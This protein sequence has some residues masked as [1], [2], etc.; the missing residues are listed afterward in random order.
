VVHFLWL[1]QLAQRLCGRCNIATV[2]ALYASGL[3][4]ESYQNPP[5]LENQFLHR[6]M[7]YCTVA[8]ETGDFK[9]DSL[10]GLLV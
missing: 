8:F 5:D 7:L 2:T 10:L 3:E 4:T 6:W 9:K 1:W